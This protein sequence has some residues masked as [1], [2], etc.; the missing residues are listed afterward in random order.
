[1]LTGTKTKCKLVDITVIKGKLFTPWNLNRREFCLTG[2][3]CFTGCDWSA[4]AVKEKI[5]TLKVMMNTEEDYDLL[6]WVGMNKF[7]NEEILEGV[8]I[9]ISYWWQKIQKLFKWM[10]DITRFISN[11]VENSIWVTPNMWR[12]SKIA[13]Q[14][15]K[16]LSLDMVKQ[17]RLIIFIQHLQ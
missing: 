3:H 2:F 17:F 1:M 7:V 13:N 16:L 6:L 14:L 12:C 11:G 15:S 5:H 9:C 8:K 10:N 4:F